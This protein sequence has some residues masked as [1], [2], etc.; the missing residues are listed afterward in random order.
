MKEWDRKMLRSEKCRKLYDVVLQHTNNIDLR[1]K[2]GTGKLR[3]HNLEYTYFTYYGMRHA[4]IKETTCK[5]H[6]TK[7][8]RKI[9]D[10]MFDLHT[11]NRKTIFYI[12]RIADEL[13]LKLAVQNHN[14]QLAT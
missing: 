10:A 3:N 5:Q 8:N 1:V 12:E 13:I 2:T 7:S 4:I 6:H 9:G 14:K 11:P